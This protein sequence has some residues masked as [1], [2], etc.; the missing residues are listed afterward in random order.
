MQP[1]QQAVAVSE[2]LRMAL[3]HHQA[4]R[5]TEAEDIYQKILHIDSTNAGALHLLGAIA[6][7]VGKNEIAVQL[8][9]KALSVNPGFAEA[10]NNLGVAL[11]ALGH[12][13]AATASFR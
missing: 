10:H 13:D 5:L 9:R 12:L 6:H 8:I 2:A 3:E 4:G 11:T 1:E 7:Q